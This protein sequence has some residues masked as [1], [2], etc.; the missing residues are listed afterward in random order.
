MIYTQL[1]AKANNSA[2]KQHLTEWR[3]HVA[4]HLERAK[5]I[6]AGKNP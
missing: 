4:A 2:L 6:Q 1:L 5:S 3:T